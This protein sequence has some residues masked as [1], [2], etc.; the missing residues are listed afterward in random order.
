MSTLEI[1]LARLEPSLLSSY[2]DTKT[3]ISDK[4]VSV[5]ATLICDVLLV[6]NEGKVRKKP[7]LV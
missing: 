7:T 1:I 2:V 3:K 6:I 4:I 5:I